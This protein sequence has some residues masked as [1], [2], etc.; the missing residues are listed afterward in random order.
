M[1]YFSKYLFIF[2]LAI[3]LRLALRFSTYYNEI[4]IR[5]EI[6]TPVN[7]WRRGIF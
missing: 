3:V 7:A 6:S 4:L 5:V 2:L 1:L